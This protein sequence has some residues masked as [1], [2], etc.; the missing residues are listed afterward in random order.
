MSGHVE[1]RGMQRCLV[2]RT[3]DDGLRAPS[4]HQSAGG[5]DGGR[6]TPAASRAGHA[7]LHPARWACCIRGHCLGQR[8]GVRL[9]HEEGVGSGAAGIVGLHSH[10]CRPRQALPVRQHSGEHADFGHDTKL[11]AGVDLRG[12]PRLHDHFRTDASR[13][14][15]GQQHRRS[16]GGWHR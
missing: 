12:G 2:Q 5:H 13:I 4:T 8:C 1:A 10:D 9:N 15:A 3:G 14:A 7:W 16:V 6:G 11:R